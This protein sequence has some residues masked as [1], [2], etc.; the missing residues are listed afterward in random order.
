MAQYQKM[1]LTAPRQTNIST[2]AYTV[3]TQ[4]AQQKAQ[5]MQNLSERLA[6]FSEMGFKIGA[7]TARKQAS[8]QAVSDVMKS[9]REGKGTLDDKSFAGI[10]SVYSA[11]YREAG[12]AT[13]ASMVDIEVDKKSKELQDTYWDNP[14]AYSTEMKSFIE[15]LRDNAPTPELSATIEINGTKLKNQTAGALT[16]AKNKRIKAQQAEIFIQDNNN[17]TFQAIN[18]LS[19]GEAEDGLFLLGKQEEKL[20]S[21]VADGS[22]S[23]A[24]AEKINYDTRYQVARGVAINEVQFLLDGGDLE[25]AMETIQAYK[26]SDDQLGI[27][28]NEAIQDELMSLV[29]NKLRQNKANDKI[30]KDSADILISDSIKVFTSGKNPYTPDTR[31]RIEY[32][33][34]IVGP[35]KAHEFEVA[36][37]VYNIE[38]SY[39]S[40]TLQEQKVVLSKY[41]ASEKGTRESVEIQ[42]KLKANLKD[43]FDKSKNDP[44]TLGVEQGLNQPTR[45]IDINNGIADVTDILIQ[46]YR[47]SQVNKATYGNQAD[48]IFTPEEAESLSAYVNSSDTSIDDQLSIINAIQTATNGDTRAAFNQLNKKGATTFAYA[49][50]M[51]AEGKREV[52]RGILH[53]QQTM[54]AIGPQDYIKD[55]R[56]T[57][58]SKVGN[59]MFYNTDKMAKEALVDSAL[60]YS[61]FLAEQKGNATDLKGIS[62]SQALKDLTNGIHKRNSQDFF[63]PKNVN[64]DSFDE[65]VEEKVTPNDFEGVAN[66]SPEQ[67]YLL[68][69]GNKSKL[70]SSGPGKY[71]IYDNLNRVLKKTDGSLFELEYK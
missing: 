50:S 52:A 19:N 44:I 67:A 2:D 37:I 10:D 61:V 48:L 15:T 66:I 12:T 8:Q 17:K 45:A 43:R 60:A 26:E 11:A 46:R 51:I 38:K 49:G 7:E 9:F 41:L 47:Q 28:E 39:S 68:F 29:N 25:G 33:K 56:V 5:G 55:F 27:K 63:L 18:L 4:Q 31:E 16:T 22:I 3:Q 14:S 20:Q 24:Q 70:V 65:W 59:A 42:N 54:R 69:S 1:Q 40:L 53:G 21:L 58:M 62:K 30:A 35:K 34:S 13:Y 36:E 6:S 64:E 57:L 32:A 71:V 23:P